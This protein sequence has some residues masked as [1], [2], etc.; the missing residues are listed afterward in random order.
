MVKHNAHAQVTVSR[1]RLLLGGAA[2]GGAAVV[3]GAAGGAA[4]A[5]SRTAGAESDTLADAAVA[6]FATATVDPYG[7]HQAGI[8]TPMQ[9]NASF[10]AFT[11]A[12]GIDQ[13]ALT[14][15]MKLWTDDIVR[16]TSGRPALAD[17]VP[18]LSPDPASLTIT[19]GF[20]PGVF[21]IPG[22]ENARPAWLAPLPPISTDRLAPEWSGG[23]LIVQLAAN[24]PMTVAHAQQV[25]IIDA[26]GFA[27]P[28]WVQR[29][30]HRPVGAL[31][32]GAVGR[33]LMGQ[34]DGIINPA[35]GTAEFDELVW[36]TEPDWLVGGTGMVVRRIAMNLET[37]SG[38]DVATKENA[39]GRTMVDGAPLSGGTTTDKV[40]LDAVDD[41]GLSVIPL[42]AHTR[43]ASPA[44][45]QERFLRRPYN[46]DHGMPGEAGLI[47]VA[48]AADIATQYVPV[49][50]RLD[51]G[52][53]LNIWTTPVGSAVVAVPPGFAPGG[54][55]GDTLLLT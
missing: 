21:A 31:P 49:H 13:A 41:R 37:W 30:F 9:S 51:N 20:G 54:F 7:A 1:R 25:L 29:G 42:A 22:L 4:V 38:L 35:P 17:G 47:F 10:V 23:D 15:L 5:T 55:I 11:L 32:Q 48:F 33:N 34:V 53:L 43:L 18:E 3:V 39:I 52:D 2:V 44:N 14:R 26:A 27:T 24:D 40:D 8:A 12:P 45:D 50:L 46:Y 16:L 28:A 36:S 19:V 6:A